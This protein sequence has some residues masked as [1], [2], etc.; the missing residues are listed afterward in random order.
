M[1]INFGRIS[2]FGKEI[3]LQKKENGCVECISHC[4]DKCGYTRI[5]ANGKHERLFR[6]IYEQKYGKIPEGMLV[7]HKCDN[8]SCVNIEHLEIGTP[9]DNVNDMIQRG[10]DGYHKPNLNCRGEKNINNKLTE[11]QVKE[12]YLNK[13][14]SKEFC[15][16]FKISRSL[17][18]R[19]RNK[20]DWK[21]FT[22]K[23]DKKIDII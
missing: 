13:G 18:W 14:K 2:K 23:L 9:K 11:E 15:E 3:I 12:I 22:D 8:P 16:K 6:Y 10:R 5:R 20:I 21:W 4:K 1:I 7:R 17:I 19:I